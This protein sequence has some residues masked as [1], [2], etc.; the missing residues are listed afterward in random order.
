MAARARVCATLLSIVPP[1]CGCGWQITAT[2]RS[3][4]AG[5]STAHSIA[6]AGPGTSWRTVWRVHRPTFGGSSRRSTTWPLL[7]VRV[8][9]LVDV[10]LVDVGVPDRFGVDHGHRAAGAAVQA[11]GLVDAHAARPGQ[12]LALDARLAVVEAR[13][14]SMLR[15][16]VLAVVALVQ[17]EED[18]P[19]VITHGPIL[20]G[21]LRGLVVGPRAHPHQQV[22]Q[23]RVRPQP[24]DPLRQRRG[25]G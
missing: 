24:A 18:V 19:L 8:D 4:P 25:S 20:G 13:L 23:R 10:V 7:Q 9:D 14:R 22:Q 5:A 11:A 6:P 3:A 16:G 2:P 17:A 15:A 21:R 1:C 12:A